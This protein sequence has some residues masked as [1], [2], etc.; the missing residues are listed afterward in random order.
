MV[1]DH[2]E[3]HMVEA[4]QVGEVTATQRALGTGLYCVAVLVRDA[5]GKS[6][7]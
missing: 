6:F 4:V 5:A 7:V 2:G 1:A 3:R